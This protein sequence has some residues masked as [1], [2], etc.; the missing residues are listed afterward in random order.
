MYP[1]PQ[2]GARWESSQRSPHLLAVFGSATSQQEREEEGK[3]A[4][5]G[6]SPIENPGYAPR[7]THEHLA[8]FSAR[9]IKS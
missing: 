6:S 8:T 2:C 7:Q 3:G 5:G 1:A 4:E 9:I